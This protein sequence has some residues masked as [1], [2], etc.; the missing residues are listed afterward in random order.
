MVPVEVSLVRKRLKSAIDQARHRAQQRRQ[1][2]AEAER[3][4]AQFLDSVAV[5]VARM[6]QNALQSEGIHFTL[7]T[8]NGAVRLAS[9]RG[10]NDY[11]ELTLDTASE[12]PEVV[13]RISQTRGSRT[14]ES[15]RAINPG[16]SPAVVTEED[17]LE[18]FVQAL[19][20]WL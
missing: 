7:F 12:V 15:E 3:A 20:P 14:I 4:Y 17:V 5:P 6:V 19:E 8:P 13:G 18:F 2:V 10:R 11:V 1:Q 9:D 16:A